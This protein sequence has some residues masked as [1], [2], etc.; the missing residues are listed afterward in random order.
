MGSKHHSLGQMG[1][2]SE[3]LVAQAIWAQKVV[4]K[5]K[6]AQVAQGHVVAWGIWAQNVVLQAKFLAIMYSQG[7]GPI[8]PRNHVSWGTWCCAL[9]YWYL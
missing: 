9:L 6:W 2:S 8:C 3:N 5:D 4:P 7:T 1:L